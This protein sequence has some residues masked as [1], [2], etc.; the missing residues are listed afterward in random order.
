MCFAEGLLRFVRVDDGMMVYFYSTLD[1]SDTTTGTTVFVSI[2]LDEEFVPDAKLDEPFEAH[3]VEAL[4]MWLKCH[5]V[6]YSP[7][8]TKAELFEK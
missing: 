8:M 4:R 5:A 6:A 3:T 1:T 2:E 7:S